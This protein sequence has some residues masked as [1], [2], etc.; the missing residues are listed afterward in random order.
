MCKFG[1]RHY[2]EQ[3]CEIILNLDRWFRGRC[4]LK[5]FLIWSSVSPFV[6]LNHL[7]NFGRRHH[8]E[9]FCEIVLNLDW[10]F[11]KRCRLKLLLI[12]LVAPFTAEWNHLYNFEGIMQE[13]QFCEIIL[14]LDQW[15]REMS[16]K[17][18]LIWSSGGIVFVEAELF[19]Q[20][21][22]RALLETFM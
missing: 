21:W 10:W 6:Q 12:R 7:C 18:F 2:K 13:E 3:F 1:R 5:V 17:I 8:E 20:F 14:I 16:F 19:M 9:Q 4:R 22:K 15:F 11:R